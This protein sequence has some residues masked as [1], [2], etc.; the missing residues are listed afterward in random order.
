MV[1]GHDDQCLVILPLL[2]QGGDD[3]AKIMIRLRDQGLVSRAKLRHRVLL[4]IDGT[5]LTL[6]E[7]G[8]L[9]NGLIHQGQRRML[10][11]HLVGR[12]VPDRR[13]HLR[14]IVKIMIFRRRDKGRVRPQEGQ[15]MKERIGRLR[16]Q[17]PDQ[18][19]RE[20]VGFAVLRLE[21]ARSKKRMAARRQ[22]IVRV[23]EI[24]GISGS[25]NVVSLARQIVEPG[26]AVFRE[27]L[28]HRKARH[29]PFI[30][31]EGLMILPQHARVRRR[32]RIAPEG[33]IIAAKPGLKREVRQ[34]VIERRTITDGA[35]VAGIHACQE[36]RARRAAGR[37]TGKMIAKGDPVGT[38]RVHGRG[39]DGL[40][41]RR[42]KMIRP[43]LIEGDK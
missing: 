16:F 12:S 11:P 5:S 4:K 41:P 15:V 26:N 33:R 3:A 29:H 10:F 23:R 27:L 21:P 8:I 31:E 35:M 28:P 9:R 40:I 6:H 32:I 36:R 17:V 1:R 14:R 2:L 34:A 30:G 37:N 7:E 20:P 39:P 18:L 22:F 38:E 42:R 25:G 24:D 13:R 19:I 43:P